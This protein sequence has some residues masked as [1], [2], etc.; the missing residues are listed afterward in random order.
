MGPNWVR[1][2]PP[3]PIT[4]GSQNLGYQPSLTT[5]SP[6]PFGIH[7]AYQLYVVHVS[8]TYHARATHNSLQPK[9]N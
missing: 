3:P 6:I 2:F 1:P 8:T 7:A 5:T 4:P 9:I